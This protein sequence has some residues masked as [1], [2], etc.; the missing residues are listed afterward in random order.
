[1]IKV[2]VGDFK[3]GVTEKKVINEVLDSGRI[4]EGLK[5]REFEKNWA[6]FVGTKYAMAVSEL[7]L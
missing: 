2:P 1:M 5:V 7:L 3:L 6:N 4:S